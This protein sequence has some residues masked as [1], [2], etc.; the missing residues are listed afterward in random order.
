LKVKGLVIGR[1]Q[2][3]SGMS[4][5]LLSKI[6]NTKRELDGM[7]VICDV[8]FGYTTPQA[9]FPIGGTAKIDANNGVASI[10][11]LRN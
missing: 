4:I 11:I 6:V 9:T 8:D 2:K 3:A 1:F 5:E 7:P 10:R